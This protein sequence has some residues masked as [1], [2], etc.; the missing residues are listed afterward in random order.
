MKDLNFDCIARAELIRAL[1]KVACTDKINIFLL[2][3][4]VQELLDSIHKVAVS[5][6][7]NF[8]ERSAVHSSIIGV[9]STVKTFINL[10]CNN[11]AEMLAYAEC[12]L[13]LVKE[14]CNE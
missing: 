12:G 4:E 11:S 2:E 1:C 10:E 9:Y 3:N 5:K 6:G 13:K 14:Y 7:E 8:V